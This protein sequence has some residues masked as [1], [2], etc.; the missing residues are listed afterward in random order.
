MERGEARQDQHAVLAQT[1]HI[2]S[3]GTGVAK[4]N[5]GVRGTTSL[6]RDSK[7]GMRS[8]SRIITWMEK[9]DLWFAYVH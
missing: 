8:H 9:S 7:G 4:P 5:V 1:G 3:A 2:R 6:V